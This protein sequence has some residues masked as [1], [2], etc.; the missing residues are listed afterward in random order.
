MK[1][2]AVWGGLVLALGMVGRLLW[3]AKRV[4]AAPCDVSLPLSPC[5]YTYKD[6]TVSLN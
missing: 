5:L 3:R 4:S 2:I 6:I 1:R